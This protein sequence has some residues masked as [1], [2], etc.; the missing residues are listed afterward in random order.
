MCVLFCVCVGEDN[1]A[2]EAF[3]TDRDWDLHVNKGFNSAVNR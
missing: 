2:A 3:R 1:T